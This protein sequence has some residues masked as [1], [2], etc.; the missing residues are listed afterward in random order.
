VLQP[1]LK[2]RKARRG[3]PAGKASHSSAVGQELAYAQKAEGSTG[4]VPP[5]FLS[6]QP[7]SSQN[8]RNG[9]RFCDHCKIAHIV[10]LISVREPI[11]NPEEARTISDRG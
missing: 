3:K 9:I 1:C 10:K 2:Q 6:K 7:G 4:K 5:N 11:N 8:Q